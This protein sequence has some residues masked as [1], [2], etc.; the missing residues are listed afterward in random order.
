MFY[1]LEI[2]SHVRLP[3]SNFDD[4]NLEKS[5][6]EKLNENYEGRIDKEW[7]I[8]IVVKEI[9]KIGEGVI[10]PGDGAAYYD[11]TFKILTFKPEIQ[12]V[13]FGI[14]TDITDFGVFF[15]M[16]A[17]DGMI[18]VS[19]TMDD[20]VSISKVGVLT[21]KATK[22]ILKTKDKCKARIVAVSYKDINNPKIGLTMRQPYLGEIS[23]LEE[24]KKKAKEQPEEKEGKKK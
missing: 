19:Q 14:V 21:G 9:A 10:V 20:F 22:Q 6:K 3:P 24:E 23:Y 4:K 18:H 2:Q 5:L 17:I 15:D 16:G 7:G 1:E 11:V 12:E 13:V 8:V